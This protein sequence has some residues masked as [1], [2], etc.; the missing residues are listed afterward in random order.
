MWQEEFIMEIKSKKEK[1][2]SL[3]KDV[4]NWNKWDSGIE[5]S[6]LDGSF[7]NG[8]NGSF[9]TFDGK[10]SQHIFFELRNCI[11]EK[12]FISK[13]RLPLCIMDLGHELIEEENKLIIRHYI[14]IYGILE[15]IYRKNIGIRM[16]KNLARSVKTLVKLAETKENKGHKK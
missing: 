15:C 1:I 6:Y 10:K 4:R 13:V 3:W 14:R 8:I 16:A 9:K 2:W 11:F 5:Y 12:S 7:E